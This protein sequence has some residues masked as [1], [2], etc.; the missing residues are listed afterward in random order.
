MLRTIAVLALTLAP[1]MAFAARSTASVAVP[2][3]NVLSVKA[4]AKLDAVLATHR[5]TVAEHCAALLGTQPRS[6]VVVRPAA[7]TVQSSGT[8]AKS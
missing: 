6:V 1:S 7:P 5:L 3:H 2:V 8:R 4:Q